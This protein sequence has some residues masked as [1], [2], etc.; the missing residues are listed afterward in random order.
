MSYPTNDIGTTR[1]LAGNIIYQATNRML[2]P[3]TG[4]EA[5]RGVLDDAVL[6]MDVVASYRVEADAAFAKEWATIQTERRAAQAAIPLGHELDPATSESFRWRELRA[7]YRS[8]DRQGPMSR[9]ESPA[10]EWNP[11]V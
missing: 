1:F 9:N 4:D 6:M 3:D 10:A 2:S 8:L 11:S 5:D 7:M